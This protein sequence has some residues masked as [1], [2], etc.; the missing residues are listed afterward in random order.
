MED[1]VT[2]GLRILLLC[3]LIAIAVF[4][5]TLITY[6]N[7]NIVW[8][9]RHIFLGSNYIQWDLYNPLRFV[10]KNSK[11]EVSRKTY[12]ALMVTFITPIYW[13]VIHILMTPLRVINA[14]YFDILLFLSVSLDDAL[15]E[16]FDP[17]KGK[18]R[19]IKG[20]KYILSWII[21][22]PF[23]FSK[24]ILKIIIMTFDVFIMLGTSLLLPVL[25][26]YHGTDFE[27]KATNILQTGLWKVGEGDYAGSGIYFGIN[28]EVAE[29]Y[30]SHGKQ[31][32]IIVARVIATFTRNQSTLKKDTRNLVGKDG[33]RLSK[34]LG[35][36]WAT[37][38][39]WRTDRGGWWEYCL[40]QPG[41]AR[42]LVKS[43]RIRPVAVTKEGQLARVWGGFSHY[44]F[45]PKSIAIGVVSWCGIWL[46]VGPFVGQV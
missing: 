17:K 46:V 33:K 29:H 3:G 9:M 24:L 43:W 44:S 30:A 16:V 13:L 18:Y 45:D 40:V 19:K 12:I 32:T 34:D 38:E 2:F 42:Q 20:T 6:A 1:L 26:M 28:R 4:I 5:I 37:I 39:H 35:K 8:S 14:I 10:F 7:K 36:P 41:R 23:R 25:T 15:L 22:L 21:G 27:G 11:S 31:S